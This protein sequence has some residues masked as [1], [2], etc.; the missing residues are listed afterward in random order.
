M[1]TVHTSFYPKKHARATSALW[2]C[3]P[4]RAFCRQNHGCVGPSTD[5]RR[6]LRFVPHHACGAYPL[7][8][9]PALRRPSSPS[10]LRPASATLCAATTDPRLGG[11]EREGRRD[12]VLVVAPNSVVAASVA[13]R[14]PRAC[15]APAEGLREDLLHWSVSAGRHRGGPHALEP[16]L[17]PGPLLC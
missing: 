8:L 16:P 1:C 3:P 15:V 4:P 10:L 9:P 6:P 13:E 5:P 2:F 12:G 11:V 7:S 17:S 14:A